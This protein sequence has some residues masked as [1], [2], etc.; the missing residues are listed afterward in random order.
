MSSSNCFFLIC[1]LIS[2][3]ASQ[4]IWFP[5]SFRTFHNIVT[6]TVKGF[7]TVN[8]AEIIVFLEIYCFLDGPMDVG[9]LISG[10]SAFSKSS[11]NIWKLTVHI[12][13]KSGLENFE[14]YFTSIWDEWNCAVVW[15]FLAL[16][17]F[18]TRIKTDL[19]QSCGHWWIF[20]SCWYIACSTFTASSLRIWNSSTGI[21][22][23]EFLQFRSEFHNKDFRIW[24]TVSSQSCLCW[25]YRASPSLAAKNIS[26]LN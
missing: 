25:L 15:A 21:E 19:F 26:S 10:S 7:S 13:L 8:K 12:L 16:P 23:F 20:Q 18:G 14:H 24:S 11:L 4:A 1:I 3:E 2:Q 5:I 17:F 9:N 6:L 22:L